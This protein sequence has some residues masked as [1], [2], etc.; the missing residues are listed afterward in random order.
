MDAEQEIRFRPIGY[1]RSEHR[2]PQG[3]PIQGTFASDSRGTIEILPEFEAGLQDIEGFSHIFVLYRFHLVSE[4][5]LVVK[6]FLD[7]QP[8]GVFAVRAPCRPNPIGL[9]IVR[10]DRRDGCT[11]HVSELDIVD[12][13]PVIDIKPYVPDFD[14]RSEAT[15]GWVKPRDQRALTEGADDRFE[16]S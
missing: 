13:T 2:T 16:S 14:H 3:T 11:L 10:L 1:V 15:S 5:K 6:P 9:S 7:D 12:G 8:H 4:H